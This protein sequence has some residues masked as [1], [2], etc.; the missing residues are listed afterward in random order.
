MEVA[1]WYNE[2][3]FGIEGSDAEL[4]DLVQAINR[5]IKSHELESAECARFSVI[6]TDRPDYKQHQEKLRL[7]DSQVIEAA[8]DSLCEI[9][10]HMRSDYRAMLNIFMGNRPLGKLPF[11]TTEADYLEDANSV[12]STLKSVH[13]KI[14]HTAATMRLCTGILNI[15]ELILK[16]HSNDVMLQDDFKREI[17]GT[18][19]DINH[20]K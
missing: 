1:P 6:S 10:G 17:M 20:L 7:I 9:I 18:A 11:P 8:K 15:L 14:Q 19:I 4:E 3:G 13:D 2:E 16:K 12:L 5:A